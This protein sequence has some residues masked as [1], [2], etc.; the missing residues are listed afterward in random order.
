MCFLICITK[1][2]KFAPKSPWSTHK[3][4]PSQ[5]EEKQREENNGQDNLEKQ[6]K[7]HKEKNR[8]EREQE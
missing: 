1:G 2:L 8:E 6:G 5:T 3:T 7:I 4:L